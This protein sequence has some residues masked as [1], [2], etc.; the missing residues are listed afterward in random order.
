VIKLTSLVVGDDHKV[1]LDALSVML[2]QQ[3]FMVNVARTVLE[4]IDA[5]ARHQPDVCLIDRHFACGN[6]MCAIGQ[7]IAVSASTK[8]LVLSAD[9]STDGVLEALRSGASG[10]LHKTRG[11][12]ALT[13]AISRILRGEVVVDVPK[14]PGNRHTVQQDGMQRLAGYLTARERE[15]LRLLVDGLDTARMATRLGV[16]PAT[17]RTHVQSLLT[18]LGVHSRLE[19]A[20]LAVRYRLLDDIAWH[21]A[22]AGRA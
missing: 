22:G 8:V 6:G 13:A 10:Y 14:V 12:T 21:P 18:K 17:V 2:S 5:V 20:S 4:T 3:N 7:V 16:S 19:A 15:C 1:F 11:V 9:A